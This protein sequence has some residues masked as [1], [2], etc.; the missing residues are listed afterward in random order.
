MKYAKEWEKVQEM[1]TQVAPHL[2]DVGAAGFALEFFNYETFERDVDIG[3]SNGY[4][5]EF[6]IK[7]FKLLI[8]TIIKAKAIDTVTNS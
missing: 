3:V 8:D 1:V 7:L 4:D 5:V 2:S 6:Q